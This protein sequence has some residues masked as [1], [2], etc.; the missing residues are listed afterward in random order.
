[1]SLYKRKDSPNWWIKVSVN[2]RRIQQS[3]GTTDRQ[4]AEEYHDKLK[5]RLW[6]ENR[7]G[8]K[9]SY[10][11]NDAVVR[12]L[13]ETSHKATHAE[14]VT[15]L[16]WLDTYLGGME[17]KRINRDTLERII[18]AKKAEG[19][20]DSTVNRFMEIVRAI[21]RRAVFEWEWLDRAPKVRMFPEPKRRVRWLTQEEAQ[22]LI[23][24]LPP[25]LAAMVRFTLET[26]L[27]R[28]NV[29]ML[30]WSQVDLTRR[31]AW[32]HPDQAKAKK[33]I[34][35]P[36]TD[37]A[38]DVLREQIGK[39]ERFVFTY[40]GKPVKQPNSWAWRK[41]LRK[42]GI[43]DFRWHDLRHT[44]ASWHVQA[45]TP[46]YALQELGGWSCAEMVRTYAH[47]S[48]DHLAAFANRMSET[49][50]ATNQLRV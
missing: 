29:T 31:T 10:T 19:A 21:L 13:K 47:L 12:W 6:D 25:H 38:V 49:L 24:A 20:S 40:R 50:K 44:W 17:L 4:K 9:P 18:D 32:I 2:G 23:Q 15:K 48:S 36:L 42:L 27:R 35:V 16:R 34:P 1:M 3:T 39:H 5:A 33:A 26:G 11:W 8:I 22:K 28:R 37:T 43:V 14:D 45:G 30:E 46:L 41:T 7:L